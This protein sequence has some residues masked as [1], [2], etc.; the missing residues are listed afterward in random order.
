MF[1]FT[2]F[3]DVLPDVKK[4]IDN[5]CF[6]AVDGEFSG[7]HICDNIE[8]VLSLKISICKINF[9]GLGHHDYY[10]SIIFSVLLTYKYICSLCPV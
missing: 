8:T 6:I 7:N 5:C 9:R 10:A 1:C 2:D 3:K 4:A